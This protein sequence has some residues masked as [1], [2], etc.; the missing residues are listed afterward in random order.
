[1][2]IDDEVIRQ[3]RALQRKVDALGMNE[4]DCRD[5]P[6]GI[7]QLVRSISRFRSKRRALFRAELFGE[8]AW[9]MLLELYHAHLA[10]RSESTDRSRRPD[11]GCGNARS[12]VASAAQNNY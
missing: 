3:V 7:D 11:P 10:G 8:P 6:D 12:K 2:S 4:R 1:M 5:V 9:D